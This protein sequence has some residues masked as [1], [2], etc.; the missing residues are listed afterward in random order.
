MALLHLP[1]LGGPSWQSL[2]HAARACVQG[3]R[4]ANGADALPNASDL[5]HKESQEFVLLWPGRATLQEW[6]L[7]A[8]KWR[9]DETR[10]GDLL[11]DR[12]AF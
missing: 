4:Y 1:S 11:H 2:H 7:R 8:E 6:N 3:I 12:Q 5:R 10:T 9:G